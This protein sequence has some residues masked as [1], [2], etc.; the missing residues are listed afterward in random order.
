MLSQIEDIIAVVTQSLGSTAQ[1]GEALRAIANALDGS[2]PTPAHIHE[3]VAALVGTT[4][5]VIADY[6]SLETRMRESH[7]EIETLRE[8]LETTRLESLTDPLTGL[9]NRKHFEDSLTRMVAD[10]AASGEAASLIVIDVDAFKRFNDDYGHLTGDQVLRLVAK[11]MREH[12]ADKGILARFGGEEFGILL[13]GIGRKAAFALAETI[14]TSVMGRDLVKR[15]TGESLGKITISLGIARLRP[16]DTPRSLLE[17][18][19]QCMFK[20]KR[21]GR[22]RTV[23]DAPDG[24]TLSDVA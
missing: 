5:D 15:S 14:R 13:P 2:E 17:R 12:I 1:Y 3:I 4:R 21:D 20:A 22:N 16:D 11:V 19:D 8:A 9:F 23:D 24:A 7:R 10:S 18:A 6:Q